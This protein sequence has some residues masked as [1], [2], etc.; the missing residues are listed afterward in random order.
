MV[1]MSTRGLSTLYFEKQSCA[2]LKRQKG[3]GAGRDL[4]DMPRVPLLREDFQ[5]F[6]VRRTSALSA[7]V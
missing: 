3:S 1:F 7:T 2:D 4:H 5:M 6:V